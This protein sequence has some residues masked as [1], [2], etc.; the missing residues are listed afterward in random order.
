[1]PENIGH[2]LAWI[3]GRFMRVSL[4][5]AIL[6]LSGCRSAVTETVATQT[7]IPDSGCYG[8]I[9]QGAVVLNC[10][11]K[12]QATP[13]LGVQGFA[14]S[15][16]GSH[17]ALS[18][19]HSVPVNEDTSR[20]VNESK[21]VNLRTKEFTETKFYPDVLAASCGKLIAFRDSKE[22]L[23]LVD[24]RAI[25]KTPYTLFRCSKNE[26]V[27]VGYTA[28]SP[29]GYRGRALLSGYPPARV[30]SEFNDYRAF[31]VSSNGEYIAFTATGGDDGVVDRLCVVRNNEAS[32]CAEN[33]LISGSGLS[34]S[35]S[36]QVLF[37]QHT[38]QECVYEDHWHFAPNTEKKEEDRDACV[39]IFRWQVGQREPEEIEPLGREPQWIPNA[40][41]LSEWMRQP[42]KL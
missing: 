23:D 38:G 1:M 16:D 11:G 15:P 35:D 17:L 28:T 18:R 20:Q 42:V 32:E 41:L 24:G 36:G 8:F 19:S 31:D 22:I 25:T 2:N 14:V 40:S 29:A 27:I 34:V 4:L 21:L 39:G 7:P 6:I 12:T 37:E 13:D 26:T 33:L 30:I 10:S 9:R 3:K 5:L